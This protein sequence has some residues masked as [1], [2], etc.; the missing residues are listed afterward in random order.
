MRALREI[1]DQIIPIVWSL[2]EDRVSGG[3]ELRL[4]ELLSIASDD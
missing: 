3:T 2:E 1:T 4:T